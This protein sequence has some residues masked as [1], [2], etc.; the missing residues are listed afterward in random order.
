MLSVSSSIELLHQA[1]AANIR[2]RVPAYHTHHTVMRTHVTNSS[3]CD[4]ATILIV[5]TTIKE[6]IQNEKEEQSLI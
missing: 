3:N 4:E 2:V 5:R 6:L 1:A